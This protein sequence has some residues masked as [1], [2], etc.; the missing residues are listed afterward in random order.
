MSTTDPNL[1][2]TKFLMVYPET[3]RDIVSQALLQAFNDDTRRHYNVVD[4]Q[5]FQ[6]G[7]YVLWL[8]RTMR[9]LL[10][11]TVEPGHVRLGIIN[12]SPVGV[13]VGVESITGDVWRHNGTL[14][15]THEEWARLLAANRVIE[16]LPNGGAESQ[17][18]SQS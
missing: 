15:F 18:A 8:T 1:P 4:W 9:S 12:H 17:P 11:G 16:F 10:G 5:R 3:F 13:T 6:E 14:N 2:L 7:Q